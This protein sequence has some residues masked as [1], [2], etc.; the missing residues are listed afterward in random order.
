MSVTHAEGDLRARILAAAVRCIGRWGVNKTSLDDI[1]R[2]AGCSRAS[3]YRSFPGGKESL[4]QDVVANEVT[5]FFEAIDGQLRQAAHLRDLLLRGVGEA[6]SRLRGHEALAFLAEF[7]PDRLVFTPSIEG[8]GRVMPPAVTFAAHHLERFLPPDVAPQG[9]EWVV[10]I[11]LSYA[12][13]PPLSP[14]G[15][16]DESAHVVDGLLMPAMEKLQSLARR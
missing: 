10:R 13:C 6:L 11:V 5:V 8:I 15:V 4:L 14:S 9:A 3:V 1:A 7:E 2:E 12:M 16:D